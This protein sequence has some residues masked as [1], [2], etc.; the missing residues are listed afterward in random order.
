MRFMHR[1][2]CASLI[3]NR[4]A[5]IYNEKVF[6]LLNNRNE[7]LSIINNGDNVIVKGLSERRVYRSA[8]MFRLLREGS[9]SRRIGATEMNK[10]SSRS[11]AI[12]TITICKVTASEGTLRG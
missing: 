12:F 6:D 9:E 11:H 8:D 5:E 7:S 10:Q 3:T 4:F 2:C 1:I